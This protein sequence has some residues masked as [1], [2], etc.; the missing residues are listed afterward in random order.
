MQL[1]HKRNVRK[2][3]MFLNKKREHLGECVFNSKITFLI[4][5]LNLAF[6]LFGFRLLS[7]KLSHFETLKKNRS[8]FEKI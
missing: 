3:L 6:L 2:N 1:L 7:L 4:R 5:N 8:N